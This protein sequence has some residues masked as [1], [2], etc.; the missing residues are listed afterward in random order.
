MCKQTAEKQLENSWKQL[1]NSWKQLKT[2]DF[3][4]VVLKESIFTSDLILFL[5]DPI[6]RWLLHV[7]KLSVKSLILTTLRRCAKKLW[8]NWHMVSNLHNQWTLMV[9][10]E[11]NPKMSHFY[12][13]FT[14]TSKR[15]KIDQN[16]TK[17]YFGA[18]IQIDI[19]CRFV[20]NFR[21]FRCKTVLASLA[22][23][24]KVRLF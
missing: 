16:S 6:Y 9:V 8:T 15:Q 2:A 14:F 13:I 10:F 18:K 7:G 5:I 1:K 12:N 4:N 24:V 3:S 11:N 20:L 17:T 21:I 19:F 22:N 23:V